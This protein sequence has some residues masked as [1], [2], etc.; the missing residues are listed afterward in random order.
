MR[1]FVGEGCTCVRCEVKIARTAS[2]ACL[3]PSGLRKVVHNTMYNTS[4]MQIARN[5]T[6][7]TI[8]PFHYFVP[9]SHD[10]SPFRFF[11]VYRKSDRFSVAEI[12]S[13]CSMYNRGF[14][15]MKTVL[16]F[17]STS[18]YNKKCSPVHENVLKKKK[19]NNNNDFNALTNDCMNINHFFLFF[20]PIKYPRLS[21]C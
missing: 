2:S 14:T 3:P 5:L 16:K 11:S 4:D 18:G 1:I 13:E 17:I 6:R 8:S 10:F 9:I 15:D 19:N 12:S 21:F 20:G 7:Y